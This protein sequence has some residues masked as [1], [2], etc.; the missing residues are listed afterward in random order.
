MESTITF[1]Q[2]A[3]IP[4]ERKAGL[5]SHIAPILNDSSLYVH[6][7]ALL[8]CHQT[9]HRLCP[10]RILPSCYLDGV[11]QETTL[12]GPHAGLHSAPSTALHR[13]R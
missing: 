4:E 12:N 5:L 13:S 2:Q 9:Q 8:G 1:C 10:P 6:A 11:P 3:G 7:P